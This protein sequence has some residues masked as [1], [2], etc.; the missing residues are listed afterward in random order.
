MV[1]TLIP[2]L[3]PQDI[4]SMSTLKDSSS[5]TIFG[6]HVSNAAV[7]IE[8]Q[9]SQGF[10]YETKLLLLSKLKKTP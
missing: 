3:N 10:F 6:A 9:S 8:K 2:F 4:E 5:L 7:I 1:R